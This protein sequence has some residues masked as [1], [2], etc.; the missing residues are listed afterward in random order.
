MGIKINLESM[1][2]FL[3][4]EHSPKWF[5][6]YNE[7]V[8]WNSIIR[9]AVDTLNIKNIYLLPCMRE[10]TWPDL[11]PFTVS[12]ECLY[13][14]K[15]L[16]FVNG[17]LRSVNYF[18]CGGRPIK[19][20]SQSHLVKANLELQQAEADVRAKAQTV[21]NTTYSD[22]LN[23][24]FKDKNLKPVYYYENVHLG[25]VKEQIKEETKGLSGIYLILNIVTLDYYI[26]SAATNRLYVRFCNHLY[27]FTGSKLLKSAVKKYGLSSFVFIV[28]EVLPEVVNK[29][30]AKENNKNLLSLEDKYLKALLPAYNVLTEAGNSF[31]YKHTERDKIKMK[32]N[33]SLERRLKIG[34]LNKGQSLSKETIEKMRVKALN[35]QK[36]VYSELGKLNM[37]KKSHPIILFNLDSTVYGEYPSIIEASKSINCSEKTIRRALS[38][39]KKLLRGR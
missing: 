19:K 26:G 32:S 5:E 7:E 27:N 2:A 30:R 36:V 13:L 38:T 28:L 31:G 25:A 35:R 4:F 17:P 3:G 34:N 18:T 39:E 15:S 1:T 24:F 8:N 10:H 12:P 6:S 29:E 22:T 23:M 20:R 37:K 21:E 11:N 16:F 9:D 33:Y 14:T